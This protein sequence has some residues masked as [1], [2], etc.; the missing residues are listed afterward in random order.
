M[1]QLVE[2]LVET[3]VKDRTP[4]VKKSVV[5]EILG[6]LLYDNIDK[7]LFGSFVQDVK[8]NSIFKW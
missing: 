5:S 8:N 6:R 2:N 3:L 1:K 7:E 4:K